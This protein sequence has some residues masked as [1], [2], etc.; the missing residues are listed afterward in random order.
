MVHRTEDL[1]DTKRYPIA[2]HGSAAY[3]ALVAGARKDLGAC[4]CAQ[5]ADFIRPGAL[6]Q[7]QAEAAALADRATY[8]EKWL[9]PYFSTPPD[10]VAADHP[11]KRLSLRRHGMIRADRFSQSGA[12]R[13]GFSNEDLCRFVA[14]C[15][16]YGELHTYKDPYG[17]VNVNVQPPGCEFAWH[18]DH[19]DFTVSFGLKQPTDGGGFEFV[20][21]IRTGTQE[22]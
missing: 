15:L 17:S 8:T 18:F 14:D 2:E 5:L 6:S 12:I 21:D 9:N 11:L 7:M 10:H 3:Q 19:N 13:A 1:F 22:N 4:N 20:P 16:G